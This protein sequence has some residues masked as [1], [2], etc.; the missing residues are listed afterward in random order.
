MMDNLYF[1]E[2]HK[3]GSDNKSKALKALLI[4]LCVVLSLMLA[5][6]ALFSRYGQVAF[7]ALC[8]VIFGTYYLIR[9]R[10]KEYEYIFTNGEIDID[11]ISGKMT[12]K[13]VC[14]IK[15][16]NVEDIAKYST[17]SYNKHKNSVIKIMNLSDN[18]KENCYILIVNINHTK[19]MLIIS[20]TKRLIDAWKPYLKKLDFLSRMNSV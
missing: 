18:V 15:P 1:D 6:F 3:G 16:E 4:V 12:R 8:G 14:T 5:F 2:I 13:R 17:E 7:T 9:Y 10:S 19:M 11:I 20:P